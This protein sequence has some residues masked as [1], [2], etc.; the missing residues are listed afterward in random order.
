MPLTG[1]ASPFS[2]RR[3]IGLPLRQIPLGTENA[4]HARNPGTEF[5]STTRVEIA[6][7]VFVAS[8]AFNVIGFS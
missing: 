7:P 3:G 6:S 1:V 8:S 5:I 2:Q 4:R